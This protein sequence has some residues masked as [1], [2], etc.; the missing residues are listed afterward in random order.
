LPALRPRFSKLA[1][2]SAVLA[3]L[4]LLD[5][6]IRVSM[7]VLGSESHEND[8]SGWGWG[9]KTI[10]T[11][12]K[13]IWLRGYLGTAFLAGVA[14]ED[15]RQAT[16]RLKGTGIA[17]FAL[18]VMPLY[19][20][21]FRLFQ[22]MAY[23]ANATASAIPFMATT[24]ALVLCGGVALWMHR[25]EM[26]RTVAGLADPSNNARLL[27]KRVVR[28]LQ[29]IATVLVVLHLYLNGFMT[30][31]VQPRTGLSGNSLIAFDSHAASHPRPGAGN[32]VQRFTAVLPSGKVALLAVSEVSSAS[33]VCWRPDGP[34]L[35]GA[36]NALAGSSGT[37]SQLRHLALSL[38][39]ENPYTLGQILP[40]D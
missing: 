12:V 3:A 8:P 10:A 5:C 34:F 36:T 26:R 18:L 22:L 20:V 9:R 24:Y 33:P 28:A 38:H 31:L 40:F 11:V 6:W 27:P 19:W 16:G 39:F 32:N 37:Q 17:T 2:V 21:L 30:R 13:W 29:L 1:V 7:S 4:L 14:L 23:P 15:I 25:N 35:C